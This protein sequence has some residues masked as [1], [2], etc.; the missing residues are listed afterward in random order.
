[1]NI[2]IKVNNQEVEINNY[3]QQQY[4]GIPINDVLKIIRE[5][6]SNAAELGIGYEK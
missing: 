1:M 5:L 6:Q 4:V 3:E 2:K